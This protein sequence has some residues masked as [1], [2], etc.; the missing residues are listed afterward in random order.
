MDRLDVARDAIDATITRLRA[1][2]VSGDVLQRARQPILETLDNR[3]KTNAGWLR[4][5]RRAQSEPDRIARYLAAA[6]RYRTMTT[7]D[8]QAMAVRYLDPEDA[9]EITV[10]PKPDMNFATETAIVE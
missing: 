2:P 7:A 3:L 1:K 10:L 6:E 8:L 4:Y 5:V 9:L